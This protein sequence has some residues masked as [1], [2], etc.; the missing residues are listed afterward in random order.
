MA[1]EDARTWLRI[2]GY[3]SI[4]STIDGILQ[5][6]SRKGLKTRRNWW[7]VLA[8]TFAGESCK[9]NGITIPTLNE[10]RLRKKWPPLTHI[11]NIDKS[12]ELSL[13]SSTKGDSASVTS[14]NVGN[15]KTAR[16][17]RTSTA[18][19]NITTFHIKNF[20]HLED[21]QV[22][23]ADLVTLVGPQATGKSVV[24]ELLKLA[25][26][27][28]RIVGSLRQHGF[29]WTS[30]EEFAQLY[31][32]GGFEKSWKSSTH[33]S[34]GNNSLTLDSL[35]NA[36]ANKDDDSVFY[37]PAHRTLAIAE[38][39]PRPFTQYQPETPYVVRR[40]S[41]ALLTAL[42]QGIVGKGKI[43]PHDRRLKDA[44][45]K[46]IDE[47]IFHG[48]VLKLNTTGMRKQLV[49]EYDSG[50]AR[51]PYMTWTAGQREFTPLLLG[52]Y[53]LLP[54]GGGPKKKEI[55]WAIIEEPEMGLHPKAIVAVMTLVLDLLAR[56]YK[57]ALSTHSPAVLETIWGMSKIKEA[58]NSASRLCEMM[59]L[60]DKD[61]NVLKTA[62]D[63][64][65]KNYAVVHLQH[66]SEGRVISKDIS[67]LNPGADDS[68]EWG[69]G[70]L[71]E[72]SA[73]VSEVVSRVRNEG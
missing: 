48:A 52:L 34:L 9:V 19:R 56:N 54:A 61:K 8:G 46:K 36:R 14:P 50:D 73:N 64:L 27:K 16:I 26:D 3:E 39:W 35:A 41:E 6:W 25:L 31:F 4:A 33:L 47:A 13:Q 30:S 38:G 11:A 21:V 67:N 2:N 42:N 10:A 72:F 24:L 57:V 45:R 20:A 37:I 12:S 70:G 23:L 69:W 22:P 7:D 17:R 65:K 51:L 49:L 32:G 5:E 29:T 62:A 59:G 66:S 43:F 18:G 58:R 53:H 28:N 60:S 55:Q 15:A 1:R 71:T 44:F 68:R 40:F 63:A